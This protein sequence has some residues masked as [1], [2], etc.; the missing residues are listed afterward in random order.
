MDNVTSFK[1][2]GRVLTEGDDN[3]PEVEGNFRKAR[4]IWML[5]KRILIRERDYPKVSGLFFKE[6]VQAV[7][8]LGEETW[9]LT[10][11]IDRALSSFQHR[12]A[13]WLAGRQTR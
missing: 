10:P 9:V 3:C 1:Y 4:K 6:F 8:L 7:L 13:R 2:L 12:V 11:R 5:M